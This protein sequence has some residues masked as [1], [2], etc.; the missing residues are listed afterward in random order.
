M[1]ERQGHQFTVT[2]GVALCL[3]ALLGACSAQR[4]AGTTVQSAPTT[5]PPTALRFVEATATPTPYP[6]PASWQRF[7]YPLSGLFSVEYPAGWGM[8]PPLVNSVVI[9]SVPTDGGPAPARPA[10]LVTVAAST[11]PSDITRLCPHRPSMQVAGLPAALTIRADT[12][13]KPVYEWD[14][15]NRA[16][17]A[18]FI[19]QVNAGAL[20]DYRAVYPHML[21][22]LAVAPQYAHAPACVPA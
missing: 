18:R 19:F 6:P 21:A 20:D 22:S 9:N 17:V 5:P 10:V 11:D 4:V 15:A 13:G 14:A 1:V 7:S 12:T 3:C 16:V 2:M 8:A